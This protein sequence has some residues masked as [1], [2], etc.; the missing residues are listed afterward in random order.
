MADKPFDFSTTISE[1]AGLP[2]FKPSPEQ[3]KYIRDG[4]AYMVMR[5]PF[6][7]HILYNEMRIEYTYA[8]PYAATDGHIVYMNPDGCKAAGMDVANIAFVLAHEVSH[9]FLGDLI[10][11]VLWRETKQV[12]AHGWTLEYCHQTMNRA[13]DYRINAMLIEGKVGKMPQVGLFDKNL[14][15]KGMEPAT[16]IYKKLWDKQGGKPM[17][18][19]GQAGPG[20]GQG[21]GG[22]DIHMDPS[23]KAKDADASGQRQ[24]AIAAAAQAAMA[25]G[26]GNLPSAL[27]ILIGDILEP[28][29]SWQ[30]FLKTTMMRKSG[31]PIWDWRY[32]DKRL[33]V[34]PD[35]MY[36]ARQA[37]TGAGTIVIGYDTSGSC[38]SDEMQRTFFSEM[39]GIVADL[40]PQELVVIWCDAAVQRV[41]VIDEPEDLEE[42]RADINASGGAPGGGGTDFRPVFEKVAELGL[43]PDMVVYLT[44]TYGSFPN[45]EPHYPTIWA[46][47]VPNPNVPWGDVV[48][49]DL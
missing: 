6:W 49:I 12:S 40:N 34:R 7:A 36:F 26:Q 3:E 9:G 25:S 23:K 47:I 32:L 37:H 16:E 1:R 15:E 31:D 14:S 8:V 29:V 11:S 33:L 13:E 44:D 19:G 22:F 42:L 4:V 35:P 41:D 2:T 5:A 48:E 28:K 45:V 30:E 10:R 17:P 20:Q 39:A 24:Q 43:E 27:K 18:Q 38:V 46:S 21:H